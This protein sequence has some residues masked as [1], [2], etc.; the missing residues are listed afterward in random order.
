MTR[1][2]LAADRRPAAADGFVRRARLESESQARRDQARRAGLPRDRRKDRLGQ[3]SRRFQR[4]QRQEILLL[5]LVL[6]AKP[7]T[8]TRRSMS[9]RLPWSR[10]SLN[11]PAYGPVCADRQ[12]ADDTRPDGQIGGR[13]SSGRRRPH[14]QVS[15]VLRRFLVRMAETAASL[16]LGEGI[17]PVGEGQP[18]RVMRRDRSRILL[19]PT[20]RTEP[21]LRPVTIPAGRA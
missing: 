7:S 4:L 6:Q 13:D 10:R 9:R 3:G 14:P 1:T 18:W 20:W 5:L 16:H 12:P 15:V 2:L 11:R 8:R 21:K 17:V 19:R